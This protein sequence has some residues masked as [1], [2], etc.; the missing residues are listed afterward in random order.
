MKINELTKKVQIYLD[1]LRRSYDYGNNFQETLPGGDE[2]SETELT[3]LSNEYELIT[4]ISDLLQ[5]YNYP[6]KY[7]KDYSAALKNISVLASL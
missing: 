4:A 3:K 1:D 5:Q 7:T 6:D 2:L